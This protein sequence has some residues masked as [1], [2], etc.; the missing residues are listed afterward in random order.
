MYTIGTPTSNTKTKTIVHLKQSTKRKKGAFIHSSTVLSNKSFKS[1]TEF[2]YSSKVLAFLSCQMT[3]SSLLIPLT[4]A[5]GFSLIFFPNTQFYLFFSP[6]FFSPPVHPIFFFSF[7]FLNFFSSFSFSSPF[8]LY[9]SCSFFFWFFF[10]L[11]NASQIT[12]HPS[13]CPPFLLPW[14]S[15]TV[16][17]WSGDVGMPDGD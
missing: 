9:F 6:L 3:H 8:N 10:S 4:Q 11:F 17:V 14:V 2:A 16:W 15:L 12:S 13:N 5:N 1:E 7:F